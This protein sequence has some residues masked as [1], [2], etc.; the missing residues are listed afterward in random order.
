MDFRKRGL[1]ALS[2]LA[3]VYGY[4]QAEDLYISLGLDDRQ[5]LLDGGSGG[6]YVL[7]DHNLIA[8]R[9]R[10]SQKDSLISVILYFLPVG[11]VADIRPEMLA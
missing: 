2:S 7:D 5:R 1:F 8:V 4:H 11:A 6:R 9:D 10:A 3:A